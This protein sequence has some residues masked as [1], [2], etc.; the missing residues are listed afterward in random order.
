[1]EPK[2]K[3]NSGLHPGAICPHLLGFTPTILLTHTPEWGFLATYG[4]KGPL[5]INT[6]LAPM[7]E[8]RDREKINELLIHELGH[9]KSPDHLS[10]QYHEALCEIG[11]KLTEAMI[12]NPELASLLS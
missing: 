6:A 5:V 12:K 4:P 7:I 11:A 8:T 9:E 3:E 1:M 10:S 2:P